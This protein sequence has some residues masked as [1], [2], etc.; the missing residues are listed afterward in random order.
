MASPPR[1]ISSLHLR[2]LRFPCHHGQNSP[3]RA[4]HVSPGHTFGSSA[5][6]KRRAGLL[7]MHA[8]VGQTF[9]LFANPALTFFYHSTLH[10]E[11]VIEKRESKT[12][13]HVRLV[14]TRPST[15]TYL[16]SRLFLVL[17]F[18]F[19]QSSHSSILCLQ[20]LPPRS[21]DCD[22]IHSAHLFPLSFPGPRSP[23]TIYRTSFTP[24]PLLSCPS[25]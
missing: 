1:G 22:R 8:N 6:G 2:R 13:H 12:N 7:V 10:S 11:G 19:A 20:R 14:D 25:R 17:L 5:I 18:P 16:F 9:R 15:Y 23:L 24:L 21:R 4:W 3:L